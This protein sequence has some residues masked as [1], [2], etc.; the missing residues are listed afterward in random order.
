[1][2]DFIKEV[3]AGQA[4]QDLKVA[5][6]HQIDI[7][8]IPPEARPDTAACL[9]EI[10]HM[11]TPGVKFKR[12]H[13]PGA[14]T[15]VGGEGY[16]KAGLADHL[17]RRL[18]RPESA[19]LTTSE[20]QSYTLATHVDWYMANS[21]KKMLGLVTACAKKCGL[22]YRPRETTAQNIALAIAREEKANGDA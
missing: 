5:I 18:G 6:M 15:R 11:L 1:M 16:L 8:N 3:E 19:V 9:V 20:R 7:N 14:P 10:A 13:R 17:K 2:T 4:Y 21:T 22:P 12:K